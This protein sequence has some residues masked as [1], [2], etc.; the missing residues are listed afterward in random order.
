MEGHHEINPWKSLNGTISR[1]L[2]GPSTKTRLFKGPKK[3]RDFLQG[4]ILNPWN[5]PILW[6]S[7]GLFHNF[8][9]V[10]WQYATLFVYFY[11]FITFIQYNHPITFIQYI[12]RGLSPSPHRLWLSGKDLPVVPSQESNS[13]LPSFHNFHPHLQHRDIGNFIPPVFFCFC[14]VIPPTPTYLCVVRIR[15]CPPM[16]VSPPPPHLWEVKLGGFVPAY[17]HIWNIYGRR[18]W[19]L[20]CNFKAKRGNST[21][22]S[23]FGFA[24]TSCKKYD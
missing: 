1:I 3:S 15:F 23:S 13:G 9:K 8:L 2:N 22:S 4:T 16:C 5:G 17:I 14:S 18:G 6:F 10:W 12:R 20:D 24:F 19:A 21:N 7:K 11:I